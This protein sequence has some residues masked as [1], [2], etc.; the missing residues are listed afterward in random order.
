MFDI[1]IYFFNS[2]RQPLKTSNKRTYVPLLINLF[3]S[4]TER[5][6][7]L[8]TSKKEHTCKFKIDKITYT[9]LCLEQHDVSKKAFSNKP[10][11]YP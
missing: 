11:V 10:Y 5:E 1:P 3:I 4:L 2:T 9:K 8:K 6:H 7:P